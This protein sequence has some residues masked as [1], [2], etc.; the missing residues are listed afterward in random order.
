MP[1]AKVASESMFAE[2]AGEG[3]GVTRRTIGT[4][5]CVIPATFPG[6]G[7]ILRV[8]VVAG[9][10]G[11]VWCTKVEGGL[12]GKEGCGL[13]HEDVVEA[14]V[15]DGSKGLAEGEESASGTNQ[16]TNDKI[17]PVVV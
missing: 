12:A 6:K 16:A 4:C 2:A 7:K 15:P 17:V 10:V 14:V 9:L 11:E 13:G 3:G 8:A 5:R 1:V